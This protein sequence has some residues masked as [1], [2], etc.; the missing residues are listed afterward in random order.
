MIH[1]AIKRRGFLPRPGGNPPLFFLGAGVETRRNESYR[2][3]GNARVGEGTLLCQFTLS[4]CGAI[5]IGSGKQIALPCG[6]LF[7]AWIRSDH[8]YYFDPRLASEWGFVWAMVQGGAARGY[9]EMFGAEA[10]FVLAVG[11]THPAIRLLR[12]LVDGGDD[13]AVTLAHAQDA[14]WLVHELLRIR[15]PEVRARAGSRGLPD[16]PASLASGVSKGGWAD[17]AGLSR[18]QLYREVRKGS[19]QS[20][21]QWIIRRRLE[22][23][24]A[25]LRL[26]SHPIAKV[27]CLSGWAD[28]NFFARTFRAHTGLS[29][30]QWR[31]QFGEAER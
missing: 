10:A 19:G 23:A 27:A 17:F 21:A 26:S 4:G 22:K 30:T 5:R 28:A 18:F 31:R 9:W 2:W 3:D 20:P 14:S 15:F 8:A 29:P 7:V 1:D 6:S 16:A 11:R 24:C 13:S 25:L 12:T